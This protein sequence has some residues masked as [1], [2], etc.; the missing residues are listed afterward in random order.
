MLSYSYWYCPFYWYP[1][2]P[3]FLPLMENIR[4]WYTIP[5][6]NLPQLNIDLFHF[7]SSPALCTIYIYIYIFLFTGIQ[8]NGEW[9]NY[10]AQV[11]FIFW[12]RLYEGSSS[13]ASLVFM[14]LQYIICECAYKACTLLK[15]SKPLSQTELHKYRESKEQERS[16]GI[17]LRVRTNCVVM[18]AVFPWWYLIGP[19]IL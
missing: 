6:I 16:T 14:L 15:I 3:F 2:P 7:P 12:I 1:H 19:T 5:F 8:P 18:W 11:T 9:I 4:T 13:S 10:Q 17:Y